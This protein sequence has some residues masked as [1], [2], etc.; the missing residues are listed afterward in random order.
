MGVEELVEAWRHAHKELIN[1]RICSLGSMR[2]R[3]VIIAMAEE[4]GVLDE[5]VRRIDSRW[6]T[7]HA[8][9]TR[10]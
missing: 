4:M 3:R 10:E 8:R 1:G 2:E 6:L 7:W 9:H 5:L